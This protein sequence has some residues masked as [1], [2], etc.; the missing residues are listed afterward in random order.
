MNP[1]SPSSSTAGPIPAGPLPAGC[2]VA[3]W[4]APAPVHT[5]ITTRAGGVSGGPYGLA[6]GRPGGLNLGLNCGDE[7]ASVL[8]NRRLLADSLP[9][10]P[11]WLRQVHGVDVWTPAAGIGDEAPCA[12]AAVTDRRGQVLAILTADCL[13]VFFCDEQ[14]RAVGLAHA[15]WRGLAAGVLEATL[16]RLR[17]LVPQGRWLAS[18]GRAIG[19]RAFEVGDDVRDVFVGLEPA[20]ADAF[21]PTGQ[22]GKWWADL[23]G[24]ASRRLVRAGVVSVGGGDLCTV[25]DAQRFYSH[26][27]DRVSGRLA[28]LIW[29]A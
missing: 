5:V 10:E 14:G 29:L 9:S 23:A 3:S 6:D 22:A 25:A 26:R 19:P 20:D 1:G 11:V 15:G 4:P 28:S 24:L 7:P 18:M 13:P 2:L 27:R 8:A 16:V 21:R 12:D 17:E